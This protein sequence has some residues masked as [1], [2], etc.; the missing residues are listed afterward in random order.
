MLLW[1]GVLYYFIYSSF[2]YPIRHK[3]ATMMPYPPLVNGYQLTILH[4]KDNKFILRE[5]VLPPFY[6]NEFFGEY[7]KQTPQFFEREVFST[8]KGFLLQELNI[9][10]LKAT[11]LG[12]VEL[13]LPDKTLLKGELCGSKGCP[14]NEII[15]SDF[16]EGS[17]YAAKNAQDLQSLKYIDTSTTSWSVLDL[18]SGVTFAYIPQP[19]YNFRNILFPFLGISQINEWMIGLLGLILTFFVTPIVLPVINDEIKQRILRLFKKPVI[20]EKPTKLK[21][22]VSPSGDEKEIEVSKNAHKK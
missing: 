21:I 8:P 11:P 5:K 14:S 20:D 4:V 12:I 17:F 15:L 10:P 1:I 9:S 2:F 3:F 19:F 18:D 7:D 16:P 22:I 6:N 13:E